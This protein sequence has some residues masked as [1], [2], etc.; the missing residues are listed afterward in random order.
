MNSFVQNINRKTEIVNSAKVSSTNR[1]TQEDRTTRIRNLDDV[2]NDKNL[3]NTNIW[4]EPAVNKMP[5]NGLNEKTKT[6]KGL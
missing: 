6:H 1:S 4:K 2:C 5:W 3:M